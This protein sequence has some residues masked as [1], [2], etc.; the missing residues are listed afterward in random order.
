MK[1]NILEI[2]LF[3]FKGK[4]SKAISNIRKNWFATIDAFMN[5]VTFETGDP[6]EYSV[7][8]SIGKSTDSYTYHIKFAKA[9]YGVFSGCHIMFREG[10]S[11]DDPVKAEIFITDKFGLYKISEKQVTLN[12]PTQSKN[13]VTILQIFSKR[14]REE[15]DVDKELAEFA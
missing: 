13:L 2:R 11:S 7:S 15:F 8:P 14:N 6:L 5:R 9:R 10:S 1:T 4:A 12:L 3:S